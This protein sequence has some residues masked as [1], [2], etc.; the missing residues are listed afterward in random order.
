MEEAE[1]KKYEIK[2]IEDMYNIVTLDN[3]DR[4]MGDMY[5]VFH[6]LAQVKHNVGEEAFK[7]FKFGKS[8][9]IDDDKNNIHYTINGEK[10][11]PQ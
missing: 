4:F 5:K 3:L 2:T 10:L 8:V 1:P 11:K 7:E 9:W 6:Q